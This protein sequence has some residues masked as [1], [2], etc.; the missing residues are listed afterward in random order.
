MRR[1]GRLVI[2]L[3]VLAAVMTASRNCSAMFRP[4]RISDG[5]Q[6]GLEEMMAEIRGTKLVFVGEIHDRKRDHAAQLLIIEELRQ[7]GVPVAIGLEM[8]T[9]D[10][11][12]ELDRWIEGKLDGV[13]LIR[14]YSRN[15][16]LPWPLYRDILL[17]ARKHRIPLVA[18]NI[19]HDISRKVA[20]E[21]FAALTEA[22]RKRLPAGITC[23]ID[24]TYRAFI[25]RA[26]AD[27]IHGDASFARFCEVQ[28]LWNKGMA[29]HLRSFMAQ[30]PG[31]TMVVLSGVG[32]AMKQG[33][34]EEISHDTGLS[35]K[36][37]LPELPELD[38]HTATVADAD[39]LL[40][41]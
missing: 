41:F 10:S 11:Q 12:A 16:N 1:F 33:I 39:Y 26:Y 35:Y 14:L 17:Y 36:V 6:I 15:W 18:L 34:P 21:G 22:E 30:N 13:S 23:S 24:P 2:L 38:R 8:F 3:L 25:E 29:L 19:P 20:Q 27:H 7:R 37:I 5:H 28:M 4:L 32:H 31:R 9:A 40:L